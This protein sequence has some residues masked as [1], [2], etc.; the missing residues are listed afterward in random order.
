MAEFV[1]STV[2]EKLTNWITEEALLLEGVGDK[3]EQ[4]RDG[5]RWMQSFLKDADAEQEK[6]ERLRNWVSQ[7]REVA[8]DV[9][10]VIETYIA[11]AASHSSWNIAAKLINLYWA[12]K[13]IGKIQSRVQNISS[14]KEHFWDHWHYSRGT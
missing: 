7:I 11:E 10:D 13:K 2:V 3:V 4:L 12:G 8:L 9:E 6:N 14:Q 5:L 1:V